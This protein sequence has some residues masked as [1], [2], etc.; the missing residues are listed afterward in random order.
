MTVTADADAVIAP[1][2][3]PLDDEDAVMMVSADD[4]AVMAP[5][6]TPLVF[7]AATGETTVTGVGVI[8][9]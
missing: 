9:V 6:A 5:T 2:A 4:D 7:E 1:T 3:A 8:G